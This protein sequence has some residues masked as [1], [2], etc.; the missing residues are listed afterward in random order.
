MTKCR[1]I[2]VTICLLVVPT[3]RLVV[4]IRRLALAISRLVV[5]TCRLLVTSYG[6]VVTTMACAI[7]VYVTISRLVTTSRQCCDEMWTG[8]NNT[9]T[10]NDIWSQKQL[11]DVIPTNGR[12]RFLMDPECNLETI[13]SQSLHNLTPLMSNAPTYMYIALN[14]IGLSCQ[15]F[16]LVLIWSN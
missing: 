2:V 14:I 13:S 12:P 4:A 1:L 3:C 5:T 9:S 6:L 10:C 8:C 7:R 15:A 11:N 16:N